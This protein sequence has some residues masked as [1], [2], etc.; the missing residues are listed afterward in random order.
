MLSESERLERAQNWGSQDGR[1]ERFDL[2][3]LERFSAKWETAA[4]MRAY[5]DVIDPPGFAEQRRARQQR[6]LKTNR[7]QKPP[8]RA[9]EFV[10]VMRCVSMPELHETLIQTPMGQAWIS[11][12]DAAHDGRPI[13]WLQIE[14][15]PG[16]ASAE[17]T[18]VD[19][20]NF[21]VDGSEVVW[22]VVK[23]RQKER[24]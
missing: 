14:D 23:R 10:C 4:Y 22:P 13:V 2:D 11:G 1:K 20:R 8:M 21:E 3:H 12:Q 7:Q 17:V 24:L 9:D 6:N 15:Y 5:A 19:F 16:Y 18:D